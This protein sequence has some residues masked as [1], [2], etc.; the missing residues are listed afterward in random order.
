MSNRMKFS[1]VYEGKVTAKFG[2]FQ[3]ISLILL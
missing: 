3:E 2:R 1:F